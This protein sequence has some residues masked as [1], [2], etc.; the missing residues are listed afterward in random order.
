M[1]KGADRIPQAAAMFQPYLLRA[2]S[3]LHSSHQSLGIEGEVLLPE[4]AAELRSDYDVSVIFLVRRAATAGD[5][6]DGRGP[7]PWLRDAAP[8]LVT[9]VAAE[10]AA[11]SVLVEQACGRL[12]IPCCDVGENFERSMAP[13]AEVL[14]R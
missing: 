13:A 5:I 14:R 4:T 7:N 9:S 12:R 2:V 8:E 10:V 1:E 11:W 6:R 3:Y